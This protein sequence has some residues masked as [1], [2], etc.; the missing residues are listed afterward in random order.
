MS[1][2]KR[3][4]IWLVKDAENKETPELIPYMTPGFI[5]FSLMYESVDLME[6]IEDPNSGMSQKQQVDEIIDLVIRIFNHQFNR[7]DI[8]QR[9]HSP[10]AINTLKE[11]VQF[12]AQGYQS[13]ETKKYLESLN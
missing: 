6:K 7:D 4:V 11:Q 13:D 1:K 9:L 5:P 8:L 3:N 2:L 10:D 12:V